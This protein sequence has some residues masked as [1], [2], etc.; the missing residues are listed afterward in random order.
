M[1]L[2]KQISSSPGN[3]EAP[4]AKRAK[5]NMPSAATV[6]WVELARYGGWSYQVVMLHVVVVKAIARSLRYRFNISG[7]IG[8]KRLY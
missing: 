2:E 1:L 5:G 3:T 6:T 7:L 4:S 8:C